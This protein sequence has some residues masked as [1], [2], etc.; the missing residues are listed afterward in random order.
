MQVEVDQ[1]RRE[2]QTLRATT[3]SEHDARRRIARL[4]HMTSALSEARTWRDIGNLIARDIADVLGASKA[5][6]ALP[7]GDDLVVAARGG[8]TAS[9]RSRFPRSA[10]LPM[11]VAYRGAPVWCASPEEQRRQ[12]PDLDADPLQA[13]ACLPIIIGGEPVG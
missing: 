6:F 12:F 2:L 4:Q 3:E 9:T 10:N 5:V 13:I 7:D 11:A 8:L 1:L